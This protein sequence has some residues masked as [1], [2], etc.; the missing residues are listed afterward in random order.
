MINEAATKTLPL[1]ADLALVAAPAPL[2]IDA[3]FGAR[4]LWPLSR[5]SRAAGSKPGN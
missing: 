2:Q 3:V 1:I 5:P 4:G